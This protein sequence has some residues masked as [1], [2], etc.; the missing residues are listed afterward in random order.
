MNVIIILQPVGQNGNISLT[1][2]EIHIGLPPTAFGQKS[3]QPVL[4]FVSSSPL[5]DA[6]QMILISIYILY[7]SQVGEKITS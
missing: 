7:I 2:Y 5:N 1:L 4:P 6:L 3:V